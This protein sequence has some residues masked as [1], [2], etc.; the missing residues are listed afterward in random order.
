[1]ASAS[2][3]SGAGGAMSSGSSASSSASVGGA[4]GS[5]VALIPPTV[6]LLA[7]TTLTFTISGNK[8]LS[9]TVVEPNRGSVSPNGAY[10][11]PVDEG[12]YHV[13]ATING[14]QIHGV[15]EITVKR[16]T[17]PS[18][19]TSAGTIAIAT[20]HGSQT[21]IVFANGTSEWWLFY[22][23]STDAALKTA[24]T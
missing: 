13:R 6:T 8:N 2:T 5:M 14:T 23:A 11:A 22:N 19:A 10:T 9:W 1:S 17:K 12:T 15:A 20:G 24:H 16:L 3:S 7:Q 4:G 21:H 18:V